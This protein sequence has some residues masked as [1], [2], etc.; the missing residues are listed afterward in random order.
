MDPLRF[1][2]CAIFLN[3]IWQYEIG[4]RSLICSLEGRGF[5]PFISKPYVE[6]L[7]FSFTD[8]F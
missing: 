1:A 3:S 6:S 5:D 8:I 2:Q 7:M 4:E